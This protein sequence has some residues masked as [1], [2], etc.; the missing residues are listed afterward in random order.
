MTL[1]GAG[2][3]GKTRL[4]LQ[5]ATVL[6]D[7]YADGVFCVQM[8]PIADPDQVISAVA[9]ALGLPDAGGGLRDNVRE[10]LRARHLLLL[11]DNFEH[12]LP[13]AT[14]VAELL[15]HAPG[16]RVLVTSREVLRVSGEHTFDVPPLRFPPRSATPLQEPLTDYAA[17]RLC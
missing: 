2:G 14:L 1:I 4:A 13:A 11:L 15:S 12:L 3:I 10:F 9:Q 16:L 5:A 8:A 6:L 7:N 17:V